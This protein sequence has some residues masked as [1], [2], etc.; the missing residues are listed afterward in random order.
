MKSS[1]KLATEVD[2]RIRKAGKMC[3]RILKQLTLLKKKEIE[4][5]AYTENLLIKPINE[6]GDLDMCYWIKV[7]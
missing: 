3:N 1:G 6:R 5:K 7:L 2:G 4:V